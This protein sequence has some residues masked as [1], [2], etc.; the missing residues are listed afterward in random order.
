MAVRVEKLWRQLAP[1][2][3]SFLAEGSAKALA[4]I[5]FVVLARFA[6]PGVLGEV[7]AAL[8][9][10]QIA[11]GLGVPF[12]TS[13]SRLGGSITRPPSAAWS[14]SALAPLASDLTG[15]LFATV[16][17]GVIA[18][19][20]FGSAIRASGA[21][22]LVTI[23]FGCSYLGTLI[24][25]SYGMPRTLLLINLV[26]NAAQLLL[27][28]LLIVG[29]PEAVTVNVV[30]VVYACAFIVPVVAS[31]S[32]KPFTGLGLTE[33]N[34]L[35][36]EVFVRRREYLSQFAQHISHALMVNLDLLVLSLVASSETLGQYAAV[37]GV[38]M[39]VLL[40]ATALFHLLLPAAARR[41]NGTTTSEDQHILWVGIAGTVVA[42]AGAFALGD[43]LMATLYGP[44]FAGLGPAVAWGAIGAALYGVS[45]LRG[46]VWIAR[47][48]AAAF[49]AIV[50]GAAILGAVLLSL[51]PTLA[52]TFGAARVWA[53]IGACLAVTLGVLDLR[54]ARRLLAGT[55]R[56]PVDG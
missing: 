23:G 47:G 11:A 52:T 14:V 5:F 22:L 24:P 56:G 26:G 53:A 29:L 27:L 30:V 51:F 9:A 38:L 20:T 13:V 31:K 39:I 10:G 45:L 6:G 42:G 15:W 37:K 34:A 1:A 49:S 25:K 55:V 7:R 21:V 28:G 41:L 3:A 16:L 32:L 44:R 17:G 12:L 50:A 35:V 48:E 4:F 18:G 2:V 54:H 19:L 8:S 40:P 36:R 46:A 43:S 33:T